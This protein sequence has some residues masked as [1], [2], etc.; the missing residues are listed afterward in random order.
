[1]EAGAE[2]VSGYNSVSF[3]IS[4]PCFELQIHMTGSL[5]NTCELRKDRI[6]AGL[7][8]KA[9]YKCAYV[10]ECVCVCVCVCVCRKNTTL[11]GKDSY[12]FDGVSLWKVWTSIYFTCVH[13]F[14]FS[15]V[16]MNHFYN[17][18]EYID[19]YR[20]C[21]PFCFS[22][23]TDLHHFSL[24][25]CTILLL[26]FFA[27]SLSPPG[28]YPPGLLSYCSLLKTQTEQD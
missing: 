5:V 1:M 11:S 26:Y 16:S 24:G 7:T 6:N 15:T 10:N 3:I 22:A 19:I 20:N 2:G 21:I 14:A 28:L 18:L 4:N 12:R 23:A 8:T 9:G 27:S 25:H 17:F 13:S